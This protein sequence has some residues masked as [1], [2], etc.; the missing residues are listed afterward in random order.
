M[1]RSS[2][3]PLDAR[4]VIESVVSDDEFKERRQDGTPPRAAFAL[5][6]MTLVELGTTAEGNRTHCADQLHVAATLPDYIRAMDKLTV[7]QTLN[8]DTEE[9]V[10]SLTADERNAYVYDTVV[11]NH[12]LESLIDNDSGAHFNEVAGFVYGMYAHLFCRDTLEQRRAVKEQIDQ[13]LNGIR[14]EIIGE[15]LLG[16]LGYD[17]ERPTV[18]DDMRGIDRHVYFEDGWK[19][20]DFKID[21]KM[22]EKKRLKRPGSLTLTVPVPDDV[23]G[24]KLRLDSKD[25]A[26][27]APY[28]ATELAREWQRYSAYKARIEAERATH[29]AQGTRTRPRR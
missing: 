10:Y 24:T 20:V 8:E 11:F 7:A 22:A 29:R 19:G 4:H 6:A 27:Y 1:L 12:T 13:T 16:Y 23:I 26:T 28:F 5:T 21:P 15:Q 25:V 3:R 17:T 14:G 18:E 9:V 2:R